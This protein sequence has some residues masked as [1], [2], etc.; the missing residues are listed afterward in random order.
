VEFARLVNQVLE[1][2]K[3]AYRFVGD[4]ITP[5]T[6]EQEIAEVDRASAGS[7]KYDAV[8]MHIA[9]ALRLYSD[10]KQPDYRN[11][12][13]EAISAIES[14]V[15]LITNDERATLGQALNSIQRTHNLH[16]AL[17][18]ALSKLYGYT[19]DEQGIRHAMLEGSNVDEADARFMLVICSAFANYLIQ[20]IQVRR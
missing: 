11:S 20:R 16:P 17:K 14:A 5:I 10:R 9:A 2:E 3:S 6:S 13:K 7:K 4:Y 12:I 18:E 15:K 1:E 8:S 19:S